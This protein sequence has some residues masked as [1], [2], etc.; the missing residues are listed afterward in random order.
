MIRA[1]ILVHG[2]VQKVGFRDFVQKVA[3]GLGVKGYVENLED[4]TVLIV[5]EA[6]EAVLEDFIGAIDVREEFIKVEKVFVAERSEATGEFDFFRIKHG[7]LGMELGE[8]M[9]TA[10]EYARTTR[11]EIR[12]MR[13]DLKG[14]I[15]GMHGDLKKMHV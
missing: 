6:D 3:R 5:C 14:S 8:R 9:G 7:D 10:I 15:E 13:S 12:E 4:G 2:D 11:L 1:R